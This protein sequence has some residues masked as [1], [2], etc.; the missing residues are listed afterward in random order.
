M[1]FPF[2]LCNT[3]AYWNTQAQSSSS[4]Q[5]GVVF[6]THYDST[7][8]LFPTQH[9]HYTVHY[10][11]TLCGSGLY[12]AALHGQVYCQE[13]E[14]DARACPLVKSPKKRFPFD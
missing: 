12:C 1:A 6:H 4:L 13:E 14:H 3:A 9:W 7:Q 10:T 5:A 2:C 11:L 8:I